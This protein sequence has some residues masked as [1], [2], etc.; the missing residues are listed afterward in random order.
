MRRG[1]LSVIGNHFM[2]SHR[3]I[4]TIKRADPHPQRSVIVMFQ[5]VIGYTVVIMS[6]NLTDISS[7]HENEYPVVF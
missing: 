7:Q 4:L 3:A 6:V 2:S 5:E 1:A